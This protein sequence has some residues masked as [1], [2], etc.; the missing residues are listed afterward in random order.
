[1]FFLSLPLMLSL[2]LLMVSLDL[3]WTFASVSVVVLMVSLG[4]MLLIK[5]V[6]ESTIREAEHSE[7]KQEASFYGSLSVS[8]HFTELLRVEWNR[9][10]S[11]THRKISVTN[12]IKPLHLHLFSTRCSKNMSRRQEKHDIKQG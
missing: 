10:G 6:L 2:L 7:R 5:M 11:M 9:L 8:T 4:I 3:S 12:H 1:M